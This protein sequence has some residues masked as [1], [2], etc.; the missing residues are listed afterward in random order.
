MS[1]PEIRINQI[2]QIFLISTFNTVF[3]TTQYTF[4]I[5]YLHTKIQMVIV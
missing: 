1:N 5:L 3:F 4:T 2:A